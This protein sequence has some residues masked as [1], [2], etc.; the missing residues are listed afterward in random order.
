MF[1]KLKKYIPKN[2][3]EIVKKSLKKIPNEKSTDNFSRS[4]SNNYYYPNF[5]LKASNDL[6]I[7]KNFRRNYDYQ[8]IL[9]H[10]SYNDGEKYL[11]EIRNNY[12]F[13]LHHF[14]IFRLNDNVGNP[15]TYE[16][17]SIGKFSPTTLR[18]IKVLG[19]LIKHFNNLNNIKICEIG[20]GYGGQCRIINSYFKPSKYTLVDIKPALMLAQTYLDNFVIQSSL[21]YKTMNELEYANY[22]LLISNYAFTELARDVQ[23]IYLNK[24]I[25]NSKMGYI[26]YNDINPD[27]YRSFKKDELLNLI[28]NSILLEE[29]PLT[30]KNNCIIF[31]K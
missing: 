31:W 2:L 10:L 24:V 5:C 19:D 18:Y 9:E 13:L 12:Q 7:F 30:H 17:N 1:Y 16:Y 11:E 20:V 23:E 15:K 29:K 4:L 3:K 21:E 6:K 8:L 27:Y 26:T 28:P 25:L 22:D 14:D